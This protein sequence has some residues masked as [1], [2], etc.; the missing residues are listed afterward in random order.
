MTYQEIQ[1]KLQQ[2]RA[3]YAWAVQ[4]GKL[5]Y[6]AKLFKQITAKQAELRR[7]GSFVT[8]FDDLGRPL[9]TGSMTDEEAKAMCLGNDNTWHRFYP[10]GSSNATRVVIR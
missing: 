7:A 3:A 4:T 2:L 10:K 5:A 6:A 8:V 1:Q 9:Q